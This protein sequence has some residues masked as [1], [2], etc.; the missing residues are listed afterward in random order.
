M[1]EVI[2]TTSITEK[3]AQRNRSLE[4]VSQAID[5]LIEAAEIERQACGDLH[6]EI[7]RFF[8]SSHLFFLDRKFRDRSVEDLRKRI[9]SAFWAAL[10]DQSGIRAVMSA[11][12]QERMNE[13]VHKGETPP[14]EPEAIQG[15]F[16]DLMEKRADML[17]EGVIDLFRRLSWDYRTNNPVR[18]GRKLIVNYV[19]DSFGMSNSGVADMLD[20]LVRVLCVYDGKPIPEHRHGVFMQVSEAI[21][22]R[23]Y[24]VENEYFSMKLYKKGTGHIAFKEKA[25]PLIDQANRVIAR[26]YPHA[27][28]YTDGR[29]AA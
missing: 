7:E 22:S 12:A 5:L 3:V 17:E 2:L 15:T 14:F 6:S 19:I 24:F 23:T 16:S 20:D 1:N 9:D 4:K 13:Q 21:R 10:I 25:L 28:A 26:H 29:K 8:M 11:Q 18:L 27:I